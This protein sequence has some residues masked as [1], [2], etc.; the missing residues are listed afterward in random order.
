MEVYYP[1]DMHW[2]VYPAPGIDTADGRQTTIDRH[3]IRII[4]KQVRFLMTVCARLLRTLI[5]APTDIQH[6]NV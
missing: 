2:Q 3:G 5:S 1:N 4:V 6:R